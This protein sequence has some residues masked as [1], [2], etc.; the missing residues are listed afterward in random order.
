LNKFKLR[1]TE[2]T[3]YEVVK[4][5]IE[6]F[7]IAF[8]IIMLTFPPAAHGALR[9]FVPQIISSE[10]EIEIDALYESQKN[11]A[12]DA[13]QSVADTFFSERIVLTTTGWV[14]HPRFLLFLT[15]LGMG[16]AHEHIDSSYVLHE[17]GGI[18]TTAMPEYEFR[19]VLLPEHPY[20]LEIYTLRRDRY[21]R[22]RVLPGFDTAGRDSGAI[23][24]FKRRPYLFRLSYELSD[25]ESRYFSENTN[26]LSSNAV[27]FK[28]WVTVAG[29]YT[30]T[31]TDSSYSRF[32]ADY[33]SDEFSLQNQLRFFQ[34]RLYLDTN[35]SR[36]SF[37]QDSFYET[38]D[39]KRLMFDEKMNIDLPWNL[40]LNGYFNRFDETTEM[41]FSNP[42][43][44]TELT[45]TTNNI[46]FTLQ[47][48]LYQSLITV[49]NFNYL[50]LESTTGDSKG[51][52]QSLSTS[53]TKNIPLG[54]LFAGLSFSSAKIERTGA[55]AVVSETFTAKIFGEFT[56]KSTDI[57]KSTINLW[58]KSALTG[59]LVRLTR[60]INYLVF[61]AANTVRVQIISI[62][63]EALSPDLSY[64]YE[65]RATYRLISEN[66]SIE[67]NTYGGSLRLELF[68]HFFNPYVSYFR[69]K[70]DIVS[71][72]PNEIPADIT[73]TTFGVLFQ[74]SPYSLLAEYQ[75]VDSN[76][77]PYKMLRAEADYRNNIAANTNLSAQLYYRKTDYGKGAFQTHE[78][79]E[80]VFGG[81]GRLQKRYPN[82]NIDLSAGVTYARASGVADRH[83][84]TF[85]G[86][87]HWKLKQFELRVGVGIGRLQV[88]YRKSEEK[89]LYQNYYVTVRRRIF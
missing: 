15:K 57:D 34:N 24:K 13:K 50:S 38:M 71:R 52:L 76:L 25:L 8:A 9:Q 82:K 40:N 87:L 12:G 32:S 7:L 35:L 2:H 16:L 64:N 28:E 75:N 48:K 72:Q 47:H 51:P 21:L 81:N 68:N 61:S 20:N 10:G 6:K 55:P 83:A 1:G 74:R 53:Y 77:N 4:Q 37:K 31:N 5:G 58:V 41:Q 45:A 89:S 17:S 22:G 86:E 43:E 73:T 60:D 44:K 27:Y 29:G 11:T 78:V 59:S 85:D 42:A 33:S 63:V 54:V 80:N 46:G 79:S 69:S 3:P 23:F 67:T 84:Y 62:P 26:T 18:H 49:Y 88:K 14:Y 56:L 30:H 36:V 65:F 70:Q 66:A 19:A 39:D